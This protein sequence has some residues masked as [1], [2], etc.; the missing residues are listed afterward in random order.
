MSKASTPTPR[1]SDRLRARALIS[2]AVSM[3]AA[4]T[5]SALPSVP[6]QTWKMTDEIPSGAVRSNS[7]KHAI[8]V[9]ALEERVAAQR[10]EL[11]QCKAVLQST[12]QEFAA[13]VEKQEKKLAAVQADHQALLVKLNKEFGPLREQVKG[14]VSAMASASSRNEEVSQRVERM[15]GKFDAQSNAGSAAAAAATR[16]EEP[17]TSS[18]QA[19]PATATRATN[20]TNNGTWQQVSSR[21]TQ[22]QE[23]T[24]SFS[25]QKRKE[26]APNRAAARKSLV[27]V[28][29]ELAGLDYG[30]PASS[31]SGTT[32]PEQASPA[33]AQMQQL[34]R[35]AAS[36]TSTSV[37]D[38][39]ASATA[40]TQHHAI[41]G[42]AAAVITFSDEKARMSAQIA[43]NTSTAS[44]SGRGA[45]R[46]F[47]MDSLTPSEHCELAAVNPS[48]KWLMQL[49]AQEGSK[50]RVRKRR[51]VVQ[52]QYDE[53]KWLPYAG[54]LGGW[55]YSWQGT[56]PVL[57]EQRPKVQYTGRKGVPAGPKKW[58]DV[59]LR[60]VFEA[61]DSAPEQQPGRTQQRKERR[62]A[63]AA[64][65]A[66]AGTPKA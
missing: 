53:G 64:G 31:S 55:V 20:T 9:L 44:T 63:V 18:A 19:A 36:P 30:I 11:Q 1:S 12:R 22:R 51:T 27:L 61:G 21:R 54:E 37:D 38:A 66:A 34:L 16:Q 65:A 25:A 14:V 2:N 8:P 57:G 33:L 48:Y 40:I 58:Q 26:D 24:D 7:V 35:G 39:F 52:V 47:A 17:S 43:L 3:T 5:T 56:V 10:Q 42:L 4:H 49:A 50:L 15:E 60:R 6:N 29:N 59:S 28:H 45:D 13:Y 41:D 32:M 46:M 23:A 62:G